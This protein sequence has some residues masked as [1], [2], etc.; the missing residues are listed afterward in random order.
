M[1][2]IAVYFVPGLAASTDIFSEIHLDS[3]RFETHLLSWIAP[4]GKDEPISHYALRMCSQIPET[5]PVLIGVSFGG[6]MVQ[7]MGKII[8]PRKTII[9]SSVKS[10]K[11]L[12][13]RMKFVK[14]TKAYKLVPS[15]PMTRI[16]S[17][18]GL[19]FGKTIK[20]RMTLYKKYMDLPD[21]NYLPWAIQNMVTWK[22]LEPQENIVHI[23]GNN[24]FIFPIKHIRNCEIVDGGT[25]V[26][27]LNKAH[28]ISKLLEKII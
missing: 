23:H 13:L 2:K 9:I 25:H 19:P 18:S 8:N 5:D 4:Q 1:K 16:R 22:Q 26:M 28:Q 24:D 20:H 27:V 3:E 17:L 21:D 15:K 14:Y 10:N 6:V 7:E 12:P 11:E